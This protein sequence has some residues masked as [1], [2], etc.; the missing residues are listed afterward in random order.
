MCQ[1]EGVLM[2]TNSHI[3]RQYSISFSGHDSFPLRHGWLEKAYKEVTENLDANPFTA[4][5]SVVKFGVGKNMVN[6]IKHWSTASNFLVKGED[7]YV[8][9]AFANRLMLGLDPYLENTNSLW[10][11]HYE[12]AKTSSNTTIYWIFSLL[13]VQSFSKEY[14]E[15]KLQEFCV[16]QDKSIPAKKSLR[17]DVNVALALYCRVGSSKGVG[18]DDISSPLHELKLL[19]VNT[20]GSYSINTSA[21]KSLSDEL[22]MHALIDFWEAAD[23]EAGTQSSSIR[24]DRLIYEEKAPGRIFALSELELLERVGRMPALSEGML[25]TSETAGVIQIFK[26]QEIYNAASLKEMWMNDE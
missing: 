22:F 1:E 4:E 5:D 16:E 12:L 25:S 6:A 11:I 8:P 7:G 19:S 23:L 21:K 10:K 13:N 9:S 2:N 18:E 17:T 14:L 15:L 26:N 20:D 24:A 3:S